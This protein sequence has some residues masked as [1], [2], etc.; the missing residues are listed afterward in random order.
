[1]YKR[2]LFGADLTAHCE[3]AMR[4]AW[5]L[6][7]QFDGRLYIVHVVAPLLCYQAG[8]LV[9]KDNPDINQAKKALYALADNH[10]IPHDNI[11][12]LEGRPTAILLEKANEL[13]IDAIV[14]GSCS[15]HCRKGESGSTATAILHGAPCDVVVVRF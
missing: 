10:F 1:M 12:V 15:L 3:S 11:F 13:D 2:V 4:K 5:E 8:S 7:N 14:V 6:A 9:E